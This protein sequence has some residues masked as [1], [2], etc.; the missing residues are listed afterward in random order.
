VSANT[1]KPVASTRGQF[2]FSW[3]NHRLYD[4]GLYRFVTPFIW[5]CPTDR[6]LEHYIENLSDSHLEIG[7]GSGFFLER[8]LCPDMLL[9]LVLLDL[10]ER[11]LEKSAQR[12]EAFAPSIRRHNILDPIDPGEPRFSSVAM[13]YVLHC[14]GGDFHQLRTVFSNV[15]CKLEEGG[16]FFGATLLSR[17]KEQSLWAMGLMKVLNWMGIFNNTEH[18]LG[19]LQRALESEFREVDISMV[20]NA[21]VFRAVK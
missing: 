19:S 10:N 9:R 20:G 13:N 16:V 5:R 8:T 3:M 21:A 14:I 18:E 11:C 17:S 12:L 2:Y 15:R 4:L 6:L 7:V 1:K